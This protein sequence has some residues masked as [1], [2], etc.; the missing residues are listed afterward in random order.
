MLREEGIKVQGI[1]SKDWES[2]KPKE[3]QARH[4]RYEF[5]DQFHR[6]SLILT[7]PTIGLNSPPV[8]RDPSRMKVTPHGQV[9]QGFFPRAPREGR[10][11]G[12]HP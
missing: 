3:R 6:K 1:P 5:I 12:Q 8:T 9:H 4:A 7:R 2:R 11:L 10:L